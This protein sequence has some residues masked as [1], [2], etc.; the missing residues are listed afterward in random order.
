MSV[1]QHSPLHLLKTISVYYWYFIDMLSYKL[2]KFADKYYR[3]SI[4]GEYTYEYE[5]FDLNEN[6]AVIH[7]GSGAFP[8][9]EIMLAETLGI[10]VVGIDKSV[11]A[12][13][14]ANSIIQK[15]GL[16]PKI[17]IFNGNG[18]DYPLDR[19]N[20]IIVSSC[21]IPMIQIID[22]I[23]MHAKPKSK[24]IIREI[25]SDAFSLAAYIKRHYNS[26]Y[27]QHITHHPFPFRKPFGWTSF[28]FIKNS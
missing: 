4:G 23:F 17:Q 20:V 1:V 7:I 19:F 2:D 27:K 14:R 5:L 12:V 21:A 15:R 26:L 13:H 9:T 3:R 18:I 25:E 6:D 16:S 24:I 10:R 8:L 22:H 28:Y 11:K